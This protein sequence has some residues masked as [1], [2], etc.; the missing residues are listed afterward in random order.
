MFSYLAQ[1]LE[2]RTIWTLAV[3][4]ISS[5]LTSVFGPDFGLT[6]EQQTNILTGL[7]TVG[8]VAA[9]YFRARATKVIGQ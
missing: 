4:A 5:V 8:T 3:T 2:S 9:G 6:P 1:L 7:I